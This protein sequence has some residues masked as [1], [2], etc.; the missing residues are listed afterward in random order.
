MQNVLSEECLGWWGLGDFFP[1]EF[2]ASDFLSGLIGLSGKKSG[3]WSFM[4]HWSSF[5]PGSGGSLMIFESVFGKNVDSEFVYIT[6][7]QLI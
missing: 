6:I 2:R 4:E 5:D 7:S 3:V 1:F